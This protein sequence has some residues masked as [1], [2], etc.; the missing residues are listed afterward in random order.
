MGKG[1]SVRPYNKAK[2]DKNWDRIFKVRKGTKAKQTQF[3]RGSNASQ[4][5]S[6]PG[7]LRHHLRAQQTLNIYLGPDGDPHANKHGS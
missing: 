6:E 2:F 7:L 3:L 5:P 4:N 1:S